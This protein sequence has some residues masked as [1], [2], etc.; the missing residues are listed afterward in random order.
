MI[1]FEV[2][3]FKTVEDCK[4]TNIGSYRS[5]CCELSAQFHTG[6]YL[7][8]GEIDM[9]G[10]A[11]T[12]SLTPQCKTYIKHTSLFY[13]E[14]QMDIAELRKKVCYLGD[15]SAFLSE[16]AILGDV[17]QRELDT[18]ET[19]FTIEEFSNDLDISDW[20]NRDMRMLGAYVYRFTAAI[21]L[22]GGKKIFVMPWQG[23]YC[24]NATGYARLFDYLVRKDVIVIFPLSKNCLVE[25]D[26]RDKYYNIP[27]VS[28]FCNSQIREK[29]S[30][31]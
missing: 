29:Y 27:I 31:Y 21:G 1:T 13:N 3:K 2:N 15:I 22:A 26:E 10:W 18:A 30:H 28:L 20:L 19:S 9:G 24:F 5:V 7:L 25:R 4:H 16:P 17:L 6:V 14:Q 8:R 23:E 11:F 12:Y